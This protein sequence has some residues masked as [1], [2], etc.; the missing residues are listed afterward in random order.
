MWA[1][2][3]SLCSTPPAPCGYNERGGERFSFASKEKQRNHVCR[4]ESSKIKLKFD[5]GG[6][7][8]LFCVKR[9]A[10]NPV[11]RRK[12]SKRKLK[13]ERVH[14]FRAGQRSWPCCAQSAQ[15]KTAGQTEKQTSLFFRLTCGFSYARKL[16]WC[17][18]SYKRKLFVIVSK[19]VRRLA[20]LQLSSPGRKR[21]PP[22]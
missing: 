19:P 17:L 21:V 9:E 20:P 6:E 15:G 16:S 12:N 18:S 4:R 8:L 5:E 22:P 2:P 3:S 13:Q 11:C 7:T 14:R 1:Y 10:E